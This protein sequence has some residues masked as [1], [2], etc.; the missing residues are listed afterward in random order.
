MLVIGVV[1]GRWL[2][3]T[4]Q[5]ALRGRCAKMGTSALVGDIPDPPLYWVYYDVFYFIVSASNITLT[6]AE[7]LQ[8]T[9]ETLQNR[10][11]HSKTIQKPYKT[12]SKSYENNIVYM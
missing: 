11:K 9:S 2:A 3:A 5:R 1:H 8:A 4:M 7:Q 10:P 6:L 12:V